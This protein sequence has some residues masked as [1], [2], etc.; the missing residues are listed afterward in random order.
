M[1]NIQLAIV[2]PTYNEEGA[3]REAVLEVRH[4]ILDVV[5]DSELVVVDDGSR[6][7]T[8]RILDQ[9]AGKDAR[10]RVLHQPNGGHGRAVLRGLEEARGDWLFLLDSDR[11]IPVESFAALW[12]NRANYQAL[13]GVRSQRNDPRL[14]LVLTRLV[15][16]I[17]RHL[18]RVRLQDANVPFKLFHHTVWEKAKDLIP[19]DCLVPSLFLAIFVGWSRIPFS[20]VE[21]PHRERATGEVSIKRWKLARF[22]LRAFS[23]LLAFRSRIKR[24]R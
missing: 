17:L 4:H 16:L 6:D 23:Q 3:I 7:S 9:L 8:G 11:Q 18:M 21:V 5:P 20:E 19:Q 15:R 1:K 12:G 2:M 10:I 13:M 14:R 22:C 24:S